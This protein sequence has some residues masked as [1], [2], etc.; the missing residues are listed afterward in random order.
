MI[1]EQAR[2]GAQVKME[3]SA[4]KFISYYEF[5]TRQKGIDIH[6]E[7]KQRVGKDAI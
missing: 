7:T 4:P 5:L 3:F 2:D 6:E 1:R